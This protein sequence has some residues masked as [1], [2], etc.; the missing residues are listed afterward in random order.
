MAGPRSAPIC[1]ELL[2]LR[3]HVLHGSADL[4]VRGRGSAALRRHGA[5]ALEHARRQGIDAG[6]SAR[7]PGGL[8]AELRSAGHAGRVAGRAGE[9]P[10]R[11]GG[12]GDLEALLRE[13]GRRQLTSLLVEGGARTI[14]G[15][16]DEGLADDFYFF[17]APKVLGD[18]EGVPMAAGGIRLTM[19]EAT[20]VFDLHWK[21]FGSDM[22]A[23]GR[24]R[25]AI[26]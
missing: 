24:F 22:L 14:G 4:G 6:R 19:S 5:L 10:V 3:Q 8:V 9:D 26:Y 12:R 23:Y 18:A 21:R 20:P 16:L 25:E 1:A 13:L 15:F 17:Y 2:R 7:R 11:E